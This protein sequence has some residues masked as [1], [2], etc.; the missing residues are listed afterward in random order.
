MFM[1]GASCVKEIE[2]TAVCSG[3]YEKCDCLRKVWNRKHI[4]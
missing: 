4:S 1:A 2:V 3:K